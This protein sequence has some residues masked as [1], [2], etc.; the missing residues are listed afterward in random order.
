[1]NHTNK[2][3]KG[4]TI[5]MVFIVLFLCIGMTELHS[6]ECEKA[7]L[8]CT[9]DPIWQAAAFGIVYCGTGYLFCKKYI[10]G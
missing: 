3:K 1:M 8:R 4:I 9:Y 2:R 5:G 6:G 7:F 10:E